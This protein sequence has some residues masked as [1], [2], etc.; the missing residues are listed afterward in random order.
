MSLIKYTQNSQTRAKRGS[1]EDTK[2]QKNKKVNHNLES[3]RSPD[4]IKIKNKKLKN[5]SRQWLTRHLNDRFVAQSKQDGYISRAVYK[6][7]ELDKKY[8]IIKD[9]SQN[10]LD[11]GAA[12]GG[13]S[14]F[15]LQKES[16]KKLAMVD[17][18]DI[19]INA[20][21][22]KSLFIKGDFTT[23]EIQSQILSYLDNKIDVILSDIA[24]NISGITSA[25]SIS[26]IAIIEEII[27]FTKQHLSSNGNLLMKI[28]HSSLTKEIHLELKKMFSFVKIAK[29][30]ASRQSSSEVYIVCCGKNF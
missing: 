27:E 28:F 18:L 13:W 19:Q 3:I 10:I 21:K 29:P 30:Q 4:T 6:L 17:L 12:P 25:D 22:K 8:K 16:L 1:V 14:E 15:V 9:N 7:I 5:S 24:P 2:K 23:E 20:S 26:M 11:L